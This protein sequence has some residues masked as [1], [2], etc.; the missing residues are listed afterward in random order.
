MVILAEKACSRFCGCGMAKPAQNDVTG[1][2]NKILKGRLVKQ[3]C[4]M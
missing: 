1:A 4:G 3:S 2:A